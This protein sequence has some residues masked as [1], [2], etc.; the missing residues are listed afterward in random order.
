MLHTVFGLKNPIGMKFY[1]SNDLVHMGEFE[2]P[3]RGQGPRASEVD[4]HDGD[5]VMYVE[6][7]PITVFL[8]DSEETF[9]V[10]EGEA[11][12]IPE[13]TRHLYINYGGSVVKGIFSVAPNL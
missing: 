9:E 5:E 10:Q 3:S 11:V 6:N 8:P 13:K 2:I 12:F 4:W 1:V 7:G